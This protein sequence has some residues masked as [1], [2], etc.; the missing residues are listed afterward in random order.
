I[1]GKVPSKSPE[2]RP[3][4]SVTWMLWAFERPQNH[5]GCLDIQQPRCRVNLS[6]GES[7]GFDQHTVK[8]TNT[9]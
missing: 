6:T 1:P 9:S 3:D 2:C 7:A 4:K 5:R 8:L